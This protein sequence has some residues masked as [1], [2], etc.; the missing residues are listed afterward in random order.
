MSFLVLSS[1]KLLIE[2]ESH[3]GGILL[4]LWI[5]QVHCYR[6]LGGKIRENPAFNGENIDFFALRPSEARWQTENTGI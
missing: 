6:V 2:A 1:K 5:E 4:V 3:L